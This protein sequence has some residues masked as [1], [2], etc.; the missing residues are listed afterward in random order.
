MFVTVTA[1]KYALSVDQFYS[2]N[3]INLRHLTLLIMS[4]YTHK[5]AIAS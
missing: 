4:C 2:N 5:T 1:L 3:T